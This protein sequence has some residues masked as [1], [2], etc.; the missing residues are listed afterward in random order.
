MDA[1]HGIYSPAVSFANSSKLRQGKE[2]VERTREKD[3]PARVR[4]IIGLG[5]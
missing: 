3:N 4:F 2:D 1:P 5:M